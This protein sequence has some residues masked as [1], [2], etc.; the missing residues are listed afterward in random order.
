M[1]PIP[2]EPTRHDA[3]TAL[4]LLNRLLNE[5]PFADANKGDQSVNRAV[6]LSMLLTPVIRGALGPVPLHLVTSP[7]S[8]SGKSYL[9]DIASMIAIGDRCP[10][11]S[12]S[13]N[14]EETEKRLVAAVLSGLPIIVLDNCVDTLESPTLCQ[15]TERPR[16]QIRPL[17][18]SDDIPVWNTFTVFANGNNAAIGGDMVRRTIQCVLDAN[19]ENPE[20]REFRT[21]PVAMIKADRGAHVA[22]ALTIVRAYICAGKPRQVKPL[23][24]YEHWSDLI[25]SALVW[26]GW[27]DPVS[28][29]AD[30]RRA[31]PVRMERAIV[32]SA[33]EIELGLD[34]FFR[35]QDL[36]K[37]AA[38]QGDLF[39]NSVLRDA[40][41]DVARDRIHRDQIDPRRLGKWLK[42]QTNI[43]S[44]TRKLI[45]DD[46]SD[47]AR[48]KWALIRTD[49]A[50]S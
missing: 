10:A 15:I 37:A 27:P 20:E 40:L 18:K 21:D 6:A 19:V 23:P 13:S 33:W 22:A 31:D 17:G 25:R 46:K 42:K 9:A 50:A 14:P 45:I 8:G 38:K 32:F 2:A 36:I 26:L 5:F 39:G 16:L 49:A 7:Q 1:P 4:A 30:T 24:S 44:G 41:L 34:G 3:H 48:P 12:A 11:R 35:T 43:I 28:T 47:Q 29:M